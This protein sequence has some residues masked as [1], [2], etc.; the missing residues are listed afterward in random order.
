M[1]Y[2]NTVENANHLFDTRKPF[3]GKDDVRVLNNLMKRLQDLGG[4]RGFPNDYQN[5]ELMILK[6]LRDMFYIISLVRTKLMRC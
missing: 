3:H 2:E 5:K 6:C 1:N 4:D